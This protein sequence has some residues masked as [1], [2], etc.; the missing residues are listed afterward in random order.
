M[1]EEKIAAQ[2]KKNTVVVLGTGSIGMRHLRI[3]GQ[4]EQIR[5]MAVPVRPD[6][7]GQLE[8]DGVSCA[9]DLESAFMQGVTHAIVA[10]ETA[11]HIEDA[12]SALELGL[13]VLIEKPMAVSSQGA[14]RLCEQASR[15]GRVIHVGCVLRFSDSLNQFRQWLPQIG[16]LHAVE[17]ECR[18]YLPDWRPSRPYQHSYSARA[19]DGGVM[20]DLIHEIDYVGWIFGWPPALQA[21]LKN[22][23]RLG[24]ESEEMARLTWETSEGAAVSIALDYLT[25]PTRRR[26]CA[27]GEHGTLQW[28]GVAQT[29]TVIVHGSEVKELRSTQ[30]GDEMFLAQDRAFLETRTDGNRDA[31]LATGEEGVH[32]LAVCDAARRASE[33]RREE[34]VEYR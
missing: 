5:P 13:D 17:V 29:V 23:G 1:F 25:R 22:L 16:R 6:R 26:M 14:R 3:L 4:M 11:R 10:T 32:A 20:R 18:S 30:T 33:S 27:F 9:R 34:Q 2:L 12:C 15:L 31:R 8:A 19:E 24:I 7:S 28:D 21:Q